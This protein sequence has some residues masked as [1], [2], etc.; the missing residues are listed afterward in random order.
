MGE[1]V[2]LGRGFMFWRIDVQLTEEGETHVPHVL[3]T[4]ARAIQVGA[5][6]RVRLC[7]CVSVCACACMFRRTER[8]GGEEVGKREGRETERVCVC[9]RVWI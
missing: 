8:R 9:A 1:E 3:G 5:C 2:R 6:A 4:I 7:V